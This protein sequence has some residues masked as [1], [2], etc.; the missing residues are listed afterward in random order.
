[1]GQDRFIAEN[2]VEG[3]TADAKLTC[4]SQFVSVV[5]V[6][7]VLD[8]VVDDS[9]EGEVFD[10]GC[11]WSHIADLDI[12][13]YKQVFRSNYAIHRFNQSSFQRAGQLPACWPVRVRFPANCAAAGAPV[14]RDQA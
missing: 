14:H 2:A 5:D 12:G 8:V 6:E 13:G 3:R 1:V 11:I 4:R 7:H 10:A 9:V